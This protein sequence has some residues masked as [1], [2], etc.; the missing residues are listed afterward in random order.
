MDTEHLEVEQLQQYLDKARN[1]VR[2]DIKMYKSQLEKNYL[3]FFN[4]HADDLY[5]AC[6]MDNQYRIIQQKIDTAE[7]PRDIE[8]Y[9]KR[10]TLYL[11]EDLLSGP[12]VRRS[13]SPISNMALSLEIECKQKLLKDFRNLNRFLQSET[14]GEKIMSQEKTRREAIPRL[15]KKKT[16][17]RLR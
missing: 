8:A 3:D 6:Y 16:G 9:L 4:W 12:L 7:T 11:E 1:E 14:V 13:T 15:E 10:C 17:P 5:K 2:S